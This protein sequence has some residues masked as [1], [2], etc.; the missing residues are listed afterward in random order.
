[1]GRDVYIELTFEA[2]VTVEAVL[3]RLGGA[4][5][6][7]VSD[8]QIGYMTDDFDWY[9]APPGEEKR[10]RAE[11]VECAADG[12]TTAIS[13]RGPGG[14]GVNVLFLPSTGRLIL[15]LGL[16]RR[17]LAGAPKLTDLAW[18]LDQLVPHVVGL[19]LIA[20]T[21]HDAYPE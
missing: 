18:Y 8:G 5:W 9:R 7:A 16:Y 19:G 4:G 20:V 15:D 13:L 10:V 14:F 3:D 6:G 12:R 21:A 2:P 17:P 11:M 1:M